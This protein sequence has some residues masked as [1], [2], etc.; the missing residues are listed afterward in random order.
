M[1]LALLGDGPQLQVQPGKTDHAEETSS[2]DFTDSQREALKQG[3]DNPVVLLMGAPGTG[4]TR[5][6]S[7]I[8]GDFVAAGETTLLCCHCLLYTSPS[9]RDRG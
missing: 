5:V 6:L 4:K 1:T 3:R 7:R 9:P 8:V 2:D